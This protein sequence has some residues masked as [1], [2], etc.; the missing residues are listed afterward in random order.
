M[1]DNNLEINKLLKKILSV[2]N[3]SSNFFDTQNRLNDLVSCLMYHQNF[4]NKRAYKNFCIK[5]PDSY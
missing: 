3:N 5:S 2:T 1:N 4:Q